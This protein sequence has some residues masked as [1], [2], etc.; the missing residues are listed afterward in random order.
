[1]R[2]YSEFAGKPSLFPL[3]PSQVPHPPRTSAFTTSPVS[4][5]SGVLDAYSATSFLRIP[6]QTRAKYELNH[7]SSKNENML[8]L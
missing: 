7:I 2:R 3:L 6:A 4:L 8:K 5:S 1:M